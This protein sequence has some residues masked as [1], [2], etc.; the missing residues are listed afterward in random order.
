MW[1]K[2]DSCTLSEILWYSETSNQTFMATSRAFLWLTVCIVVIV[3]AL[4]LLLQQTSGPTKRLGL[5]AIT[6]YTD[7][8]VKAVEQEPN[9]ADPA[10]TDIYL[11]LRSSER[12]L[13]V[14]ATD[15]YRDHYHWAEFHNGNVYVVKRVRYEGVGDTDWDDELWKIDTSRQ[16]TKL[17]TAKGLDFRVA[18]NEGTIAVL[19]NEQLTI[20]DR[21]K[22]EDTVFSADEVGFQKTAGIELI[23]W[24][25]DSEQF[26]GST[27][28]SALPNFFRIGVPDWNVERYSIPETPFGRDYTLNPNTGLL[29]YSTYPMLF[30]ANDDDAFRQTGKAMTLWQYN[31]RTQKREALATSKATMFR[32]S[33]RDVKTVEYDD[34][35]DVVDTKRLTATISLDEQ[36][37]VTLLYTQS[38]SEQLWSE[39]ANRNPA[40]DDLLRKAESSEKRLLML[41][42]GLPVVMTPNMASIDLDTF[43]AYADEPNAYCGAG[44]TGPLFATEKH[45]F[46]SPKTCS[47]GAVPPEGAPSYDQFQKCLPAEEAI[48]TFVLTRQLPDGPDRFSFIAPEGWG[49]NR[50]F[51]PVNPVQGGSP[52]KVVD[53]SPQEADPFTMPS[54]HFYEYR[55]NPQ[56]SLD[57]VLDVRLATLGSAGGKLQQKNPDAKLAGRQA[58]FAEIDGETA[59]ESFFRSNVWFLRLDNFTILEVGVFYPTKKSYDEE[60]AR[61]QTSL[62]SLTILPSAL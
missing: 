4:A 21:V 3:V 53:L 28:F 35:E 2:H 46:W 56:A 47:T 8:Q 16:E 41:N 9:T 7:E 12:V 62:D 36:I 10:K 26:W 5:P 49:M 18:P 52:M 48:K 23:G 43:L 54:A 39:C 57:D 25:D 32:P 31:L 51:G 40:F 13:F 14:T 6:T 24:S 59:S 37:P 45:L 29:A 33:W 30:D 60:N 34:P 61:I 50:W 17:S 44:V 19:A 58:A 42:D 38:T 1:G 22:K 11:R 27:L 15:V 20:I 55:F